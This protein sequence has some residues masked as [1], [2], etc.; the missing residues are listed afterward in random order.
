LKEINH[1]IV[2][3]VNVW[4]GIIGSQIVGP[5]FFDENLNGDKFRL[6]SDRYSCLTKKFSSAIALNM[7]F[8]QNACPSH[9]SKLACAALNA[10]FPNKWT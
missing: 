2:W 7:R 1:Q 10:M 8:Q 6:D 5:V 4:C 3:K 9:T